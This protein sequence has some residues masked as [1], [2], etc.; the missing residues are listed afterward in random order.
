[1]DLIDPDTCRIQ[2]CLA[3]HPIVAVGMI[4][5]H[6]AFVHPKNVDAAPIKPAGGKVLEMKRANWEEIA[7]AEA[8]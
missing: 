3:H 5:G 4:W 6:T 2:Q 8:A 7:Q 1:M